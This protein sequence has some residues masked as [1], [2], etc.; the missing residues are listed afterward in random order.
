MTKAD[1]MAVMAKEVHIDKA[2]AAKALETFIAAVSDTL[3]NK[4]KVTPVDFGFF[5]VF[6][7]AAKKSQTGVSIDIP[8]SRVP[9]FKPGI[10]LITICH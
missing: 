4:V 9:K 8:T 2:V 6:K 7:H 10:E 1:L 5:P 3:A